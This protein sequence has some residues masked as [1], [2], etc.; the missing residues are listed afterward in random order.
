MANARILVVDDV[1]ENRELARMTLEDEGHTIVLASSGEEALAA[2]AAE[3][4]DCVL[5]DIRMPGLDGF[6]TFE[7]LRELPGG[8]ETPVLFLTAQ[9]DLDN[10]DRAVELGAADFLTKPIKPIELASRIRSQLEL[11]RL[12]SALREQVETVRRQ[13]DDLM[14]L[15]LQKERLMAFVV[16]DLKNPVN[17]IDLHAQLLSRSR[18]L[19]GPAR[20]SV[21]SIRADARQLL[22]MI[23]NLLD[24]ASGEAGELRVEPSEVA[25]GELVDEVFGHMQGRAEAAELT[26]EADLAGATR[27]RADPD[28]LLRVLENLLDNALRHAPRATAVTVQAREQDGWVELSV[29]DRGPGV[30][31]AMR[32]RVFDRFVQLDE[33]SQTSRGGRGLGLAFCRLAIEA[34]GG[35]IH[36]EDAAPGAVFR[37]R[38][39]RGA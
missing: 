35:S 22:R 6:A 16:H 28:L 9:R 1:A 39:P 8:A 27:L 7:R 23:L 38:M 2:F 4:A 11:R 25:I 37:L 29:I 26:L 32:D 30:P 36:L 18:E 15:Q 24:L 14:R 12:D 21:A 34:H 17:A 13:R 33:S 31:A 3:P 10:F 19:P 20:A 5:L